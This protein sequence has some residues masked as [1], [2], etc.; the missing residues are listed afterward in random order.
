MPTNGGLANIWHKLKHVKIEMKD[1]NRREFSQ[2]DKK[3]IQGRKDLA[4]HQELMR[5]YRHDPTLFEQE[6]ILKLTLEKWCLIEESIHR[7]KSRVQWLQ[8]G[9]SNLAYFFANMR[10]RGAQNFIS[11]LMN[12]QGVWIEKE[13]DLKKE[14]FTYYRSLLGNANTHLPAI[15]DLKAPGGDGFNSCFFKKAW[16]VVGDD[17]ADAVMHFFDSGTMYKPVNCTHITLIPKVKNP[18][19]VKQFRPISCCTVLVISDNIILSHE[20]VKGYGRKGI[21]ARCMLKVDMQKAYDSVE[22]V[23]VE[24]VLVHLNFPSK[25][26]KWVMECIKTVSYSVRI[27][28][29]ATMPFDAGRGIRQGDPVSPFLFVLVMDYFSRMLKQL[30]KNPQFK[31]HPRC[32]KMNLVH[33][34]FADNL[35]LFCRGDQKSMSLLYKCFLSFSAVSSLVA[36]KDKSSIY[37]GG[38]KDDQQQ[39]IMEELGFPKGEMPLRYLGVPLS[40]KRMTVAQCQPLLEKMLGRISSWT[41]KFL[42]YSSKVQLIKNVLFSIQV[43]WSQLFVLPSK[44]VKMIEATC[45]RILWT[46]GTKISKKALLAWDKICLTLTAGG[47]NILDIRT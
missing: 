18:S 38:V 1:L 15:D 19:S 14:I 45:R 4:E 21:S 6:K 31:H 30:K 47:L 24:Q 44:I 40:T 37:F 36:N 20:L 2:V 34:G 32:A 16:T 8:L 23:F 17:I 13:A 28:S 12:N 33:L 26:V 5:D 35:L 43:F 27:N 7:Q 46:G 9:D 42:S 29:T 41:T 39:L 11:K 3:I 10:N 25:F 22:W